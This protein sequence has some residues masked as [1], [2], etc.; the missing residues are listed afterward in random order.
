MNNF[1]RRKFV[2][3]IGLSFAGLTLLSIIP[4]KIFS[5]EKNES[6]N[7]KIKLNPMSVKRK[8]IKRF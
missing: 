6:S 4:V 7:L 1:N 8:N 5:K 3:R 2:E